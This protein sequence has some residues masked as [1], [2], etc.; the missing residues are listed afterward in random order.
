VAAFYWIEGEYGYVV[1]GPADRE[2]L[3]KVASA[4]YEQLERPAPAKNPG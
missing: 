1:T 3:Q 2:L 4:T